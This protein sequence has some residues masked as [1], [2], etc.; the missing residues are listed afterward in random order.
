LAV[1]FY[2]VYE[3]MSR[4]SRI[5]PS[6][7]NSAVNKAGEPSAG[8]LGDA[9]EPLLQQIPLPGGQGGGLRQDGA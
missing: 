6:E 1:P 2:K 7:P 9:V 8:R 3:Y 4:R 5:G